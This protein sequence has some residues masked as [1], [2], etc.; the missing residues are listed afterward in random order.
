MAGRWAV[1]AEGD[2]GTS[3]SSLLTTT[4]CEAPAAGAEA[5]VW[6]VDTSAVGTAPSKAVAP[7]ILTLYTEE[8]VVEK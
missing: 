3:T 4:A 7:D 8:V 5:A 6:E 1:A 2:M